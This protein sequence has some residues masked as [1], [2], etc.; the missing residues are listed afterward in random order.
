MIS[1][2]SIRAD[3]NGDSEPAETRQG[4]PEKE[5]ET[6]I[7]SR[8]RPQETELLTPAEWNSPSQNPSR[9]RPL[10]RRKD[11][12]HRRAKVASDRRQTSESHDSKCA[13]SVGKPRQQRR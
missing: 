13:G 12:A 7:E 4:Q 5:S 8:Q 9:R 3:E 1:P 10:K 6:S 2:D 11:S